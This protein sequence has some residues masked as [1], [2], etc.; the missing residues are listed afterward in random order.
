MLHSNAFQR[1]LYTRDTMCNAPEVHG[2]AFIVLFAAAG[3]MRCVFDC[4]IDHQCS[5]LDSQ[6]LLDIANAM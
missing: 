4:F 2:L 6:S 5:L 3:W 1:F